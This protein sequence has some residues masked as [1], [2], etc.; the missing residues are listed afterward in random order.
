MPVNISWSSGCRTN[1]D[2][3]GEV[4]LTRTEAENII[5]RLRKME[6]TAE[7]NRRIVEYSRQIQQIIKKGARRA[8]RAARPRTAPVPIEFSIFE[9]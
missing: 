1:K 2:M 9:L 7:R 3:E 5:A 8:E 4:R 6:N